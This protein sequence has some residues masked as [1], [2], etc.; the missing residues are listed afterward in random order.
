MSIRGSL[1]QVGADTRDV[2]CFTVR[3][4]HVIQVVFVMG[5]S[6]SDLK[7]IAIVTRPSGM[8][9]RSSGLNNVK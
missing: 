2:N 6:L 9:S 8:A 5:F 1:I 4:I 7:F 3:F